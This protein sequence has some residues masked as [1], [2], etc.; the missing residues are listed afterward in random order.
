MK[1]SV[2]GVAIGLALVATTANA[3]S[4]VP[5]AKPVNFGISGGLTMPTGQFGDFFN[6]GYNVSGML[7]FQGPMWP[8]A[9]RVEA[10]YQDFG[11]K[12]GIDVNS[13]T[14]GGLANLLYY[15]P[16]SSIVRPYL[17]GGLG[18]FHVKV[19][20]GEESASENDLGYDLGGGL[21]FRLTGMSTFVEANWQA[22]RM[23]GE[24]LNSFPIRVGIKF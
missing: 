2:L 3:Q 13:K 10:Q 21:E 9:I 19:D 8:V 17:T 24:S 6:S 15:I 11:A 12:G 1:R 7:Q 5:V 4:I 14:I 23:D 22:I 16:T 20:G 18:Y